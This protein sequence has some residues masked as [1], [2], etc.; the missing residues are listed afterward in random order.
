[1][2]N[3]RRYKETERLLTS[4]LIGDAAVFALYLLFAALGIVVLKVVTAIIAIVGSVLCL[5]YLYICGEFKKARSRW[6]VLGFGCIVL[7]LLVS[8][9]LNYPA[10]AVKAIEQ[11][12]EQGVG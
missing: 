7:C 5:A 12:L 8:L 3:R 11:G 1:M 2:A 10:P 6:L 4:L 9:V